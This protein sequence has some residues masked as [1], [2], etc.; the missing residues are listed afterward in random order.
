MQI[1]PG[2]EPRVVAVVEQQA[3]GVV[4]DRFN[5][6]DADAFLAGY[7]HARLDAM[8]LYL[9]GRLVNAQVLGGQLVVRA[10]VKRDLEQP[11]LRAQANLNGGRYTHNHESYRYQQP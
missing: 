5:G 3:H 9:R 4:A 11:G 6:A 7:Q 2:K 8:S 1:F 10:I